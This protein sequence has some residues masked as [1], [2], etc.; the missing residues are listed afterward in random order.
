MRKNYIINT[1]VLLQDGDAFLKFEDNNVCIPSVVI[2]RLDDLENSRDPETAYNARSVNRAL[3]QFFRD[4]LYK[5]NVP[6]DGYMDLRGGGRLTIL[7]AFNE[8]QLPAGFDA[9]KEE[10]KVLLMALNV[11]DASPGIPAVL[12][13]NRASM[14]VKARMMGIEVEDYRNAQIRNG[15]SGRREL[16]LP[17]EEID[18]FY[19]EDFL[20]VDGEDLVCNEFLFLRSYEARKRSALAMFDGEK[21]LPLRYISA[22]F[23]GV[24]PRK[25][26]QIFA[27]EALIAPA[28]DIP[29]VILKGIAGTAK[30]FLALAAGLQ[31]LEEERV[32]QILLLRPQTFFDDNIGYLPGD[33]QSK[34]DP[35]LRPYYDNLERILE[36]SGNHDR[37]EIRRIISD[38]FESGMVR[39]EAF[40]YIQGRSIT[41]S[42]II[43]DE[44]QNATRLQVKGAITR[45]G[46]HSKIVLCGDPGQVTNPKLDA[47]NNGLRYACDKMKGS[48]LCAQLTFLDEE[49]QRSSLAAEASLRME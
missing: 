2:D 42:F 16:F 30:T 20:E 4:H 27:K 19:K 24:R 49:C 25:T 32:R 36:L 21:I 14:Q 22:P 40:T 26:G 28:E 23:N 8:K 39:A 38:Y 29:L 41:N 18:R 46:E 44:A 37:R 12:V 1:D 43:V 11:R 13:T 48:P 45:A 5:G 3:K 9:G 31:A 15:Y 47:Y 10:H 6:G 33:E 35:L 17:A 34:I 7:H